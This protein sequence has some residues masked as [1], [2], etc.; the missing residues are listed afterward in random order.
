MDTNC[1]KHVE[2]YTKNKF[3][4]LVHQVGF[5]IRIY[6]DART[7]ERQIFIYLYS[8]RK[9]YCFCR[10][11]LKNLFFKLHYLHDNLAP[12][13]RA[14]CEYSMTLIASVRLRDAGNL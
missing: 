9:V 4:K 5:I 7:S 2:F 14:P 12:T 8:N 10:N 6:H 3:E 11:T 13:K 1:P